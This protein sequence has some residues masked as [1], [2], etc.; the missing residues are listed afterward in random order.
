MSGL[1]GYH[2]DDSEDEAELISQSK[3]KSPINEENEKPSEPEKSEVL[4]EEPLKPS[5]PEIMITEEVE[6][7]EIETSNVPQQ[8][9]Y[10]EQMRKAGTPIPCSEKMMSNYLGLFSQRSRGVDVLKNL[11]GRKDFKNPA[12]YDL[13]LSKCDVDTHGSNLSKTSKVFDLNE[14]KKEDFY[15]YLADEQNKEANKPRSKT[16]H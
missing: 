3:E 13:I 6:V 16:H 2:Y 4:V 1:V 10:F 11:D 5:S 9:G 12:L 14:F 7:I 8:M 15:D